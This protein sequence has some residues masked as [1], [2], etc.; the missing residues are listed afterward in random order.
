LAPIFFDTF[1]VGEA[2][3]VSNFIYREKEACPKYRGF[4]NMKR[5]GWNYKLEG[6]KELKQKKE[7]T[8]QQGV[9]QVLV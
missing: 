6:I 5:G 8:S 2:P 1:T 7:A 4:Y 3:T 9:E